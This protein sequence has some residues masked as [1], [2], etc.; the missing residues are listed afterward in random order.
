MRIY[1]VI[2]LALLF[3]YGLGRAVTPLWID[4][5]FVAWCAVFVLTWKGYSRS[6]RE[7]WTQPSNR[8]IVESRERVS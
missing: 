7:A 5:A 3:A 6:K 4:L 1:F 8:T 2:T